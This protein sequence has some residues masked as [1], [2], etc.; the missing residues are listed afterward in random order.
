MLRGVLHVLIAMFA[1]QYGRPATAAST[2]INDHSDL[3]IHISLL[4]QV[5]EPSP[6]T[7]NQVVSVS[8]GLPPSLLQEKL[9]SSAWTRK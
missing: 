5:E 6:H 9:F 8:C 4:Q 3:D 2:V 7:D 1:L